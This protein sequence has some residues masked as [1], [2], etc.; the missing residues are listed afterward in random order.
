MAAP[1]NPFSLAGKTVLV[2][3][4]SSGLG[5][6]IAIS[7]SRMDARLV[8]SGRDPGRLAATFDELA[9]DGHL[10]KTADLT[11][12]AEIHAL[13]E[14]AGTIDGVVHCA[15]LQR[16]SPIK[17]LSEGLLMEIIS[18]NFVGPVMLTQRLLFRNA[19]ADGGAIVFLS[20]IA[21]HVGTAGVGPYSSMKA[22]LHG[23]T[24]C[25]A[26]EQ[27]RR[28]VRVNCIS[29]SAVETPLWDHHDLEAQRARHPLGVGTPDDVANAAIYLL[30]DASRW[31]TGTTLVMDGGV[32]WGAP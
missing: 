19:I 32:M 22:A 14:A 20:S 16:L 29:P 10:M 1:A 12:G 30:S 7:C 31:V 25:L 2:T 3:G 27:A 5:R 13:V 18:N 17:L 4:A 15:G 23:L 26:L 24:R 11:H 9:G 6:Q 21:A 8:V 28:R